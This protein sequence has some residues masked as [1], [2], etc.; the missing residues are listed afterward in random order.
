MR[1]RSARE[2]TAVIRVGVVVAGLLVGSRAGAAGPG[3]AL[4]RSL[5]DSLT[6]RAILV[7]ADSTQAVALVLV[8]NAGWRILTVR[9][10]LKQHIN[11]S[12]RLG[13]TGMCKLVGPVLCADET[14]T[15]DLLHGYLY[16]CRMIV[17]RPRG[18]SAVSF[19]VDL[20][21][22]VGRFESNWLAV[23]AWEAPVTREE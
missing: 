20:G 9:G 15:V 21:E 3:P 1:W 23:P 10:E 7:D 19:S 11:E 22:D 8:E 2:R 16:G 6:V 18:A 5:G 13:S 14:R 12:Y 17:T 4:N